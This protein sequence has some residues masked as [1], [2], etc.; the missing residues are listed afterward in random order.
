M[1][2]GLY[3]DVMVITGANEKEVETFKVEMKSAFQMSS[4][5]LFSFY[6][7]IKVHQ[8]N[9]DISLRQTPM[10]NASSSCVGSLTA[11]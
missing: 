9:S 8:D 2:V 7:G 10:P 3:V 4:P 11:T 6:L 5:R 1:L